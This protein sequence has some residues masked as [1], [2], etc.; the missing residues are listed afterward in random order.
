[1][2]EEQKIL[3]ETLLKI[4]DAANSLRKYQDYINQKN[5]KN[6]G[7]KMRLSAIA[8]TQLEI[9]TWALKEINY[10]VNATMDK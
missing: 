3:T 9:G 1:M 2:D 5:D 8:K 7:N 4:A 6:V 10:V